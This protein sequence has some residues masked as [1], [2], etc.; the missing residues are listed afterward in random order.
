[1]KV[2]EKISLAGALPAAG[3]ALAVGL[4]AFHANH[5]DF[6]NDDA[7]IS[8]RYADN[9]VRHG[10]LTYNI[11]ERV[12]GYTNFLWTMVIAAVLALGADPVPWSKA[13]GVASSISTLCA[14]FVF[15]RWWTRSSGS[16]AGALRSPMWCVAAPLFLGLNSAFAAWSEGGLETALFTFLITAGLLRTVME[17]VDQGRLPS[18]AAFFALAAMTRPDGLLIAGLAGLFRLGESCA[19]RRS[20]RSSAWSAPR[21]CSSSTRATPTP[22]ASERGR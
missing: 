7:F 8:F 17:V 15:T 19:R 21:S 5:F 11:G 12:E 1:M 9:L 16:D 22:S 6:I 4:L 14:L 2:T 3:L 20:P 18:S 13:L 10:E